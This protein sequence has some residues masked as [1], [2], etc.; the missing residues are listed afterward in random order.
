MGFYYDQAVAGCEV[1]VAAR[2]EYTVDL[3]KQA[4]WVGNV[5]VNLRATHDIKGRVVERHRHRISDLKTH[6]LGGEALLCVNDRS[7]VDIDSHH[8]FEVA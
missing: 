2:T 5:L 7:L 1:A 4:L 8:S 6:R 3:V